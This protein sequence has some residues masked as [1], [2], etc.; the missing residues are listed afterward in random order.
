MVSYTRYGTG[1]S[2]EGR[3][4]GSSLQ[5]RET[6]AMLIFVYGS[7][8][9]GMG[10]NH[11]L[12]EYCD[13]DSIMECMVRGELYTLGAFPGLTQ[14]QDWVL[15]ELYRVEDLDAMDS[16]EGHPH[17]YKRTLVP[18]FDRDIDLE[19]CHA[20]CYFYNG[21]VRAEDRIRNGDWKSYG[22]T[23]DSASEGPTSG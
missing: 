4:L 5:E 20:W 12:V 6:D 2:K 14:G 3:A 8:L 9:S 1:L 22:K 10:N 19:V 15:G 13:A 7:C 18:V 16:R 17:M 23:D 21:P 11:V